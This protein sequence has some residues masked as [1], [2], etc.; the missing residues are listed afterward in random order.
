MLWRKAESGKQQANPVQV[1][2]L[3]AGNRL[4]R[5]IEKDL[6]NVNNSHPFRILMTYTKHAKEKWYCVLEV[7]AS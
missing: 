1:Q 6:E 7:L 5:Y 2:F 4:V 3:M